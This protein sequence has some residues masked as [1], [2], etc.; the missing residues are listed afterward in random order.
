M[1][2]VISPKFTS[3]E[4]SLRPRHQSGHVKIRGTKQ[5][6][7][8][9][10]FNVYVK[11]ASGKSIRK[12]RG[13]HLGFKSKM[14]KSAAEDKLQQIIFRETGQG[15]GP[16]DKVTLD[17]FWNERFLIAR[18]GGWSDA[19]LRG[20]VTDWTRY[21]APALGKLKLSEIDAFNMQR[22]F[23]ELAAADYAKSIVQKSKTLLSSVLSYAVDLKFLPSSPM[24]AAS[25]RHVVRM[26]RCKRSAKPLVSDDQMAQ[27]IA[28]I[29]DQR[30]KLILILAYLYGLSAEEVFGLTWD[31]IGDSLHIRN[32]AWRGTLYR[33]TV[34]R[35]SRKRELPL[36]DDLKAMIADWK[37]AS[38][39]KGID[40]LF[41]GKDGESPMWPNI[42]L[43]KRIMPTVR[44]VG[45]A[46]VTF[47]I[48]RRTFSTEELERDPKSVQAIMGHA[49]P[50][51]AANIYA[52]SQESKMSA[53]LDGR[54]HRLGLG[55][56]RGVQ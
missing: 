30:D 19:T 28:L 39:G 8:Y 41:P 31:C 15:L 26:P 54:W 5:K 37:R 32:V 44:T 27:L 23:N 3:L 14:T 51:M 49:K 43:Q 22:H 33:D 18:R 11:D 55:V 53:L 25:G 7:F 40:L 36:H 42:W 50:D 38:G 47:Q 35:D 46:N 29:L 48:M 6:Y 9:G 1:Y 52:Q 17:W 12:H 4:S 56:T 16:S 21:I 10:E 24:I 2:S 20:N 45:I 34:K 13:V